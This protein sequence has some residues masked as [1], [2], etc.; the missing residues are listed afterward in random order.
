MNRCKTC[1]IPDTKPDT[2]FVDGE[3]SACIAHR[4]RQEIDWTARQSDL[5]RILETMPRNGSGYDCIVPS[6]GGKDSTFQVLTLIELGV[7]PLVVTASTCYLTEVGR[8]NIDNLKRFATTIEVSPNTEVRAKLCRLGL[9][10]VGDVSLPEHMSIFST[11]FR[12]A[13][14]LGVGTI[15][16]G[17]CP[18]AH[19]GSP[20]GHEEARTMTRRWT[21]EFGG[22]LN[23]RT[24]DFVGVDGITAADMK[25]YALPTDDKLSTVTAYW[26][27]QYL[28]WSSR[29]NAEIA[30]AAGMLQE[31]PSPANWWIGENQD[32]AL[33]GLHD[34]CMFAKYG[35]GRGC[36]QISVDIRDGLISRE[37]ALEW[38]R[39]QDGVFPWTYMGVPIERVLS[40][41][42]MTDADLNA[43]L[44]SHC[45]WDL[46]AE[47]HERK[48]RDPI[49]KEFACSQA[50]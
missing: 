28:P 29:H 36:A 35:Y 48:P 50:A 23:A 20:P 7:R 25:D 44:T 11:P 45:N 40:W 5:L 38:V 31:L 24:D 21:M 1:L 3:C 33:T 8:K 27:G 30:K 9:E 17:E 15:W 6:S 43:A 37:R 42:G 49:L 16:Y 34:F 4:S 47:E 18:Q 2:A 13:A 10:M 39:T 32:S 41:L 46:F 14:D 22:Y 19:Y 12:I 26:L